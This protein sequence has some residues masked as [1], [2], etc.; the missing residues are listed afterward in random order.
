MRK[1]YTI[2]ALIAVLALGMFAASAL[3]AKPPAPPGQG[4]CAHGNSG[5]P[6]KEDPQPEKGKDCDEHGPKEGGVN[7]D[8]CKGTTPPPPT[9]TTDTT[10]EETTTSETTTSET[11][12]E[13]TTTT[14]STPGSE[15][16]EPS[17]P[18]KPGVD[19]PTLEEQLEEQAEQNGAPQ[20]G[21]TTA[22]AKGAASDTLPYTGF[23]TWMAVIIGLGLS[24]AGL[25]LRRWGTR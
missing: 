8:H 22:D 9:T 16:S 24:G 7:E 6:C 1:C 19:K 14:P 20:A 15:P 11:T 25:A 3:A 12:T 13:E 10:T 21:A 5:K 4:E 18:S 17:Q 2:I 23:E